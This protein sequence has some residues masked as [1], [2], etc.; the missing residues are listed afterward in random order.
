MSPEYTKHGFFSIKSD[1]YSFGVIVLE[2][3]SGRKYVTFTHDSRIW[4]LLGYVSIK[5]SMYLYFKTIE[6]VLIFLFCLTFQN[7]FGI[8]KGM[9]SVER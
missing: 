2:I 3:V 4:N 8:S 9:G 5:T 1:V 6:V 7:E